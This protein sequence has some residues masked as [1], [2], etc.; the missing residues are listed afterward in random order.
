[1]EENKK[2]FNWKKF[3]IVL[4]AVLLA[5]SLYKIATLSDE[6][7]HLKSRNSNLTGDIQILREEINSIYDNVDKQ[8]KKQA[9]LISGVD[10]SIGDPSEDMKTVEF[11]LTVVPKSI[12]D[13]M[14]V[15]VTVDGNTAMLERNGN[16]FTGAI[17][18]GLFVDYNQWPL[19]SIKTADGIKTEYLEDVDVS[20]MFSRHLPSLYAD[21]SGGS[22]K[23][24]NGTLSVDLGFTV[25]TKPASQNAPV[26]F[27]SF[28]LIEEVN[29]KEISRQDITE[30]VRKSGESYN[31]RYVKNFKVTYGDKLK[32]YVIAEDSLG[33]IHK[34]LAH[35]W[36]EREDGSQAETVFGGEM[37]YD[38]DGNLLYGDKSISS[39]E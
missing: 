11:S 21:M 15:S 13:D 33:Y 1:M 9:S 29:G 23:L 18:V 39:W 27:T 7:D 25:E 34:T 19:L 22:G 32:V 35:Y 36:L 24:S 38:K 14:Q 5:F 30:E 6:I 12:S 31:T 3:I 28:T 4:M 8:L 10:F 2:Q 37:I 16:E 17:D 20:Y 26:T